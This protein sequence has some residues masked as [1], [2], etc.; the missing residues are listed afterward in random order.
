LGAGDIEQENL[1]CKP[2]V[3]VIPGKRAYGGAVARNDRRP[4]EPVTG[5]SKVNHSLVS[6]AAKLVNIESKPSV[7]NTFPSPE[8][9]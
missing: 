1:A 9:R 5:A 6:R 3:R 7:T 4:A 2:V 8:I